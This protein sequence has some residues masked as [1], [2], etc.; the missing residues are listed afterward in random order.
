MVITDANAGCISQHSE[1]T[2]AALVGRGRRYLSLQLV[3]DTLGT[4]VWMQAGYAALLTS[5][6]VTLMTTILHFVAELEL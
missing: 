1:T 4:T 3:S 2:Y 5:D 6:T